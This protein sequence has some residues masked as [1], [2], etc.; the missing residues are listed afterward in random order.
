MKKP[1]VPTAVQKDNTDEQDSLGLL[2]VFYTCTYISLEDDH[3]S[4]TE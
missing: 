2:I 4:I 1:F 3:H